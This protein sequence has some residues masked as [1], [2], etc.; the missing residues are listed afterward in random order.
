MQGVVVRACTGTALLAAIVF[1]AALGGGPAAAQ[2]RAGTLGL[3]TQYTVQKIDNPEPTGASNMGWLGI[4]N[5]GDLNADGA[6]DVLVPSYDGPGRIHI[7]SGDDGA[8]IRTLR[9]P[10]A[11]TSTAGSAGNFVYPAKLA[12]IASCPGSF[13]NLPCAVIGPGDGVPEVLVGA[14]GADIAGA[15]PDV[16]R[17]YVFDG[18]TGALLKKVQM[19]AADLASEAAQFPTGKSFSFGRAVIT[20]SSPFPA[21]APDAVKRGDLDGGGEADFVVGNPTFYEAGPATNPSCTPGP[22]AGAGRA[23]FF[24]GED[25]TGSAADVLDTPL[26]VVKNPAAETGPDHERFGHAFVSVGDV[27]TCN[28]NPGPGAVC[29]A[30]T[31]V[32]D[33]RP[34]VVV[35]AHRATFN[36]TASGAVFLFD[37]ATGALLKRYEHP[38]PQ[39]SALFG[40]TV[41]TMST[42]I[43]DVAGSSLPDIYAPAVGQVGTEVGQGRGYVLNGDWLSPTSK[44]ANVDDPTPHRGENFGT[45]ASG[46]GDVAGDARNEILVGVA[47][48]WTPGDDRTYEGQVLVV[49]PATNKTVLKFDDPDAQIGSGFGQGAVH[50]GDVNGDGLMDFATLAGYWPGAV[51]NR[52]GRLYIHR[53]VAPPPAPPPPPPPP[54]TTPPPPPPPPPA[55]TPGPNRGGPFTAKLALARATIASRSRTLDVLA[56]ITR[57]ASGRAKVQLQAAGRSHSFTAP[58][59]DKR[60]RI[61]FRATIPAAQAKLGTG[62]LTIAYAGDADTRPQTLR[63]RAAP[64]P[65]DLRLGRPTISDD[66]RLQASGT[67]ADAARGTV[68]VQLEYVADAKTTTLEFLAPISDGRWSLSQQ[69]TTAQRDAIARRDG[70]VHSYTLFTG[71]LPARMRG[72]MRTY[73][74]L[75]PR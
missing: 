71:Y 54:G 72:E 36:G 69:L 58:V 56:P 20:P 3:A 61:S 62:I 47:G 23:Y 53:S 55:A 25:V 65:A 14:S 28:T 63:L 1:A 32:P 17:A 12:D 30:G 9:F 64:N 40:Y 59:D 48:P 74:V 39:D 38:E 49:E 35:T 43:G 15:A 13:A 57:L 51:G 21:N 19:P 4:A 44:V 52:V 46:I 29:P 2:T 10:D 75:G 70:T 27:G 41:G 37:G 42:A 26:R 24:R 33:G 73:Q 45:P 68:R 60:G 11:A 66:G 7:F 8:L 67:V 34:E 6:D 16:G 50:L 22:C 5:A 18:A 31:T